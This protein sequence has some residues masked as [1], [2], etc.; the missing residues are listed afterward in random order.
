MTEE[1]Q[2][3]LR[4]PQDLKEYIDN[5]AKT[6]YRTINGEVVYRLEQSK[7]INKKQL[8][9]KAHEFAY[10]LASALIQDPDVDIHGIV[11]GFRQ[12][13]IKGVQQAFQLFLYRDPS[14]RKDLGMEETSEGVRFFNLHLEDEYFI[15]NKNPFPDGAYSINHLARILEKLY[16]LPMMLPK[17]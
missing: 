11:H 14:N 13:S 10:I 12:P 1:A 2:I 6:N 7:S 5:E 15:S 17:Q 8:E 4:V 16:F 3:K 9:D